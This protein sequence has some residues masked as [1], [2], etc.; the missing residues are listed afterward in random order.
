M[1]LNVVF[2]VYLLRSDAYPAQTYVGF[3][4]DLRRRLRDHNAGKSI[5]TAKFLPWKLEHPKAV[6]EAVR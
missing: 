4:S 5:H 2:H 3:T 6:I 1:K